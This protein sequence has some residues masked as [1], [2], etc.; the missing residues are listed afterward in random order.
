MR[1][2]KVIVLLLVVGGVSL[3]ARQVVQKMRASKAAPAAVNPQ[4][5]VV[6]AT[7]RH[8]TGRYDL[9]DIALLNN[10]EAWAV[11]YDGEHTD[12]VFYSKDSG[13]TW[14]AV[15]VPGTG[16]PFKALTFTDRQHG[17]AVGGHGLVL[18][19]TDGGK[20]WELMKRPTDYDLTAVHFVNARVGFAGGTA[21]V[22]DRISDEVTGSVE[23]LCTK[24]GGETWRRCYYHNEPILVFQIMARSDSNAFAVLAGNQ[25]IR[26]DNGGDTWQQVPLS[27]KY[28]FS[29]AFA[30]NGVGWIVGRHGVFQTSSDGGK[31]W[32]QPS[33]LTKDF[34]NRDWWAVT[35][36]SNGTGLA[37]GENSTLA[38]TTDN[39]THWNLQRAINSDDLRAVRMQE[40]AALVLGAKN[41][42]SI[43]L[44]PAISQQAER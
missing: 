33:S 34:V 21:G 14:Q 36:N 38:L 12:R 8:E 28:V 17:W 37:V 5:E 6:S 2:T 40:S 26:T 23:I 1:I 19:T 27:S 13:N 29:I 39:G 3:A 9:G 15:D 43:K 42:Y 31:T 20:S 30:P 41:L 7:S 11:G 10:G 22:R 16:F 24:D 32:Q 44:S 18:R 35:F 4:I 25:L